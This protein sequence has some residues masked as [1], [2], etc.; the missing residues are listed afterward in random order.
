MRDAL[1]TAI[2][3]G[4][5]PFVFARPWVGVLL[6]TWLSLMNPHRLAWGW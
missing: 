4:V 6:W 2:V 1:V 5:L 3:V